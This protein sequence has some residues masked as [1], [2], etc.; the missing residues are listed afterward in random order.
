MQPGYI[1]VAGIERKSGRHV[2]P[3]LARGRLDTSLL[4]KAG[5]PFDIGGLVD[6]GETQHQGS[7]P[8]TEDHLFSPENAS[9]VRD[10]AAER[11]WQILSDNAASNLRSI[12]G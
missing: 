2:R 10:L 3:V 12:F 11:F 4:V 7:P 9:L 6:L 5:G 8:E 1:C